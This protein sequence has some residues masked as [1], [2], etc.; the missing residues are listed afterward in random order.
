VPN[1]CYGYGLCRTK[2]TIAEALSVL[3]TKIPA[4][5]ISSLQGALRG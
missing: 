4:A 5:K 1:D 2:K 3:Q